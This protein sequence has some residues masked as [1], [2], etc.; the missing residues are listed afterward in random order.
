MWSLRKKE[1]V[2]YAMLHL[3]HL[4]DGV[5]NTMVLGGLCFYPNLLLFCGLFIFA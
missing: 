5:N 1:Q 2:G 4:D 3:T